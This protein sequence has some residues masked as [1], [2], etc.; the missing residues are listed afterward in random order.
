MRELERRLF[1]RPVEFRAA[2]DGKGPG[3]LGG[4][5]A[6]FGKLSQNLGGFVEECDPTAFN[7]TLADSAR[8]MCRY[9]HDDNYLLGTTEADTLV[10]GPVDETGLPYSVALPDTT[11][12]RDCAV[13][14]ARGDL[15]YSSFAF[16]CIEDEWTVTPQGFPLRRLLQVQLVDVAPVNSPAYLDSSVAVRSLAAAIKDPIAEVREGK[17]LSATNAALLQ[18]VLD[19]IAKADERFDPIVEVMRGVDDALDLAQANLSSLLGVPNPDEP[20]PEDDGT[21][22]RSGR[23][24]DAE[25]RDTHS[26]EPRSIAALRLQLD[27]IR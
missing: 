7:K 12:G 26:A 5:A 13:L 3:S 4:Y 22:T 15:R 18:S 8:V 9:N 17:T 19:T 2:A 24:E 1:A 23:T 27:E 6:V 10:L 25:Q 14:A 20:D 11:A 16:Y 21:G